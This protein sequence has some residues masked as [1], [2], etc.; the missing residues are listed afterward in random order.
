MNKGGKILIVGQGLAGT[1]LHFTFLQQGIQAD[2]IDCDADGRASAASAGIINPITGP[3]YQKSWNYDALKQIFEPL[4]DSLNLFLG[5]KVFHRM[6]MYRKLSDV[7]QVNRWVYHSEQ[8]SN[9]A[10]YGGFTA[11]PSEYGVEAPGESWAEIHEA[12]RLDFREVFGLYR[13]KLRS[14]GLFKQGTFNHAGLSLTEDSI[15]YAG[16]EYEKAIFCEGYLAANNPFFNYLPIIPAKGDALIIEK[17]LPGD[18][19]AKRTGMAVNWDGRHIWYGATLKREFSSADPDEKDGENLAVWYADDFGESPTVVNH[20]SGIRP[21]SRDRRPLVGMHPKYPAL[22]ILNG[23]GTKGTSLA[24]LMSKYL[25]D[26]MREG[27][28]IPTEVNIDRIKQGN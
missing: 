9:N 19:M 12:F 16:S 5:K 17:A 6:R 26:N 21:T 15:N 13:E 14:M 8:E 27:R 4:Y 1:V 24:P 25:V 2:I 18:F 10:C 3:K 7:E 20:L 23:L 28:E 22:A 11:I